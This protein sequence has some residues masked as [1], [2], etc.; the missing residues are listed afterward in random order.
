MKKETYLGVNVSPLTY[1]EIIHDIQKRMNAQKQSTIIAVNP[2]KI[3]KAQRDE[4]LRKLINESTYQLPDGVGVL[5]ASRL[6]GGAIRERVT[7]IDMM[8][9]LL[10]L[11]HQHAYRVFFYGAKKE[12]LKRAIKNIQSRYPGLDI[13]GYQHGYTANEQA[14]I[15]RIQ[16]TRPHILFVAL[17]SP[18]QEHWIRKHKDRLPVYIFQGVGGSFDVYAGEVKRAPAVFQK[19]GLEWLYRLITEPKRWKRQLALPRFF[20]KVLFKQSRIS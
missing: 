8:D 18:K 20:F 1:E 15:E 11:A 6:K 12:V 19:A 10:R 9:H 7:G 16:T 2:E 13:A 3:M 14:L 17:G 5:L 4:Q